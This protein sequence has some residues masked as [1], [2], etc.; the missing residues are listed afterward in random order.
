MKRSGPFEQVHS[1]LLENAKWKDASFSLYFAVLCV[2]VFFHL[3]FMCM[4][5]HFMASQHFIAW[6]YI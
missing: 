1:I 6:L 4:N 5:R 3:S 2:C